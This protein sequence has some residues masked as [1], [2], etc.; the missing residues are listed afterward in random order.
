MVIGVIAAWLIALVII[1]VAYGGRAGDRVATRIADS[2]VAEVTIDS[3]NLALVRGHLALEGMKVRK[4]DMGHLAI[5]VDTIRCELP[6]LG[7]ALADHEC[8]DLIVK[9]VRLDVSAAAVF[10]LRHPARAPMHVRH[11]EI[12]D[13]VLTFAPSAFVASLGRISIRID[14]ATAGET[15]FK[16][17]LSWIFSLTALDATIELPAGITVKLAYRDGML[18]AAG[19]IFGVRPVALPLSIPVPDSADDA[20]AEIKKLVALGRDLAEQ[21]VA[22]RAEDWLKTKLSW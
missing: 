17:P 21:L 1:G 20:V 11:V 19:G 4:E 12:A 7:I 14:H 8:R 2:L 9:G 3:S 15:T 16:T 18:T 5:D 13:A 6:P 22:Q 10:Q